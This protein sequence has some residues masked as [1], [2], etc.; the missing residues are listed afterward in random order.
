LTI[1]KGRTQ[2]QLISFQKSAFRGGY[3]HTGVGVI[4]ATVV[5]FLFDGLQ[6]SPAAEQF[7]RLAFPPFRRP[8][9]RLFFCHSDR[10]RLQQTGFTD[11][12]S[13]FGH[14]QLAVASLSLGV[15]LAKNAR[16]KILDATKRPYLTLPN[17]SGMPDFLAKASQRACA[18][19]PN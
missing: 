12:H 4:L 9:E 2:P 8:G 5:Q 13:V 7:F 19:F 3:A 16:Y 15:E 1:L 14:P 6:A 10:K 18:F 17:L 11:H